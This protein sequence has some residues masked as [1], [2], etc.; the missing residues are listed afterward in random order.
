MIIS[1]ISEIVNESDNLIDEF[2]SLVDE[3]VNP[4]EEI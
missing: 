1:K 3:S 2:K 4:E